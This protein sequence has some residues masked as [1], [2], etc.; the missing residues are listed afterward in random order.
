[1]RM[2]GNLLSRL[3]YTQCDIRILPSL[4]LERLDF[5]NDLRWDPFREVCRDQR[6]RMRGIDLRE[7]AGLDR[8]GKGL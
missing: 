2:Q 1:M 4:F 3:L 6:Q 7:K 5:G 8:D